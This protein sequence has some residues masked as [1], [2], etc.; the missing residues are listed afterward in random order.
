MRAKREG[1]GGARRLIVMALTGAALLGCG[2]DAAPS[3]SAPSGGTS[4]TAGLDAGGAAGAALAGGGAGGVMAGAACD[5]STPSPRPASGRLELPIRLV[6]GSTVAEIG[7][8]AAAP[9]GR[10]LELS[11]FKFFLTQPVL[12]AASGEETHGQLV[13]AD[14][15]PLPYGVQLVDVEDPST[16][17]LRIV[18]PE[19][20]YAQLRFGVGV[21]PGCNSPS[22]TDRV[23]PLNPDSEMFWGW[24]AQFM[25]V[26]IEGNTRPSPNQAQVA[27][28]YHVGFDAAFAH[29]IVEGALS[30]R[31]V[32]GGPT[33]ELDIAR[34]LATEAQMLPMPQHAVPDGWVS[35]NLESNQAFSLR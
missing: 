24:A 35:D 27:F 21:P 23:P 16:Q 7:V 6:I 2:G 11:L 17:A 14:G 8:P 3:P 32:S 1:Q 30:V 34:M 13:G 10:E 12:V 28:L 19:G 31:G 25:F 29:I 33:L 15:K 5:G 22:N 20:D 4:G 18:A 26:R 9:N